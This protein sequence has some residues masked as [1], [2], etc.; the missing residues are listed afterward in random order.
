MNG[1]FNFS[2][3]HGIRND[4]R[5]VVCLLQFAVRDGTQNTRIRCSAESAL[6]LCQAVCHARGLV[7]PLQHNFSP[8][9]RPSRATDTD[10]QSGCKPDEKEIKDLL[11]L[12]IFVDRLGPP[13]LLKSKVSCYTSSP[14]TAGGTLYQKQKRRGYATIA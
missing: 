1:C 12:R 2:A 11:T 7:P 4:E 8:V 9:L 10:T 14:A 6:R 3:R 13:S 5:V